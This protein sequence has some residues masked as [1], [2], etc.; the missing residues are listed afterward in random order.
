MR[1]MSNH[2]KALVHF[3]II[4]VFVL[5]IQFVLS[6]CTPLKKKFIRQ[7]KKSQTS[8]KYV[9]V[10]DPIEY[11]PRHISASEKYQHFYSSWRVWEKELLYALEADEEYK[12]DKRI[13][14]LFDQMFSQVQ[15]MR[16]WLASE[17]QEGLDQRIDEYLDVRAYFQKPQS[18]NKY[19][20]IKRKIKRIS[21]KLRLGYKPSEELKYKD[22]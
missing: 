16:K 21:K 14:Y 3:S 15:E 18:P 7:K 8:Q 4:F 5:F 20:Q 17:Q 12:N 22:L 9:P 1:K 6:S 11:A 13:V 19:I 2:S 10:L